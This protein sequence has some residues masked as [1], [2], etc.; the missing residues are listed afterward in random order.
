MMPATFARNPID[1]FGKVGE[2]DEPMPIT[3]AA[4][5]INTAI[6]RGGATRRLPQN[7]FNGLVA[8]TG[9]RLKPFPMAVAAVSTAINRGVNERAGPRQLYQL[10]LRTPLFGFLLAK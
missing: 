1:A 4:F 8:L 5:L 9:K 10:S 3:P 6:D 2:Q 7:R